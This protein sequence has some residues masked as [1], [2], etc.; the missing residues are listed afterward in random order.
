M[1]SFRVDGIPKG[2]P[3]P[4]A[5]RRGAHAGVYDPGT[6][7]GWKACV[8]LA[9]RKHRPAVPISG[10]VRLRVVCL[11]PRPQRLKDGGRIP[12]ISAPDFDNL[13]KSIADAMTDA[14]MWSDDRIVYS[15]CVDKFYCSSNERPGAEIEITQL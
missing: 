3:R 13:G 1:I 8:M 10:P 5:C 4:R 11:M 7:D 9:A 6:A 2:Q 15:G 12:F 14:G